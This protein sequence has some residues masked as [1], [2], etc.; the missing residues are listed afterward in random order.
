M[1]YIKIGQ[2]WASRGGSSY[3]R[4]LFGGQCGGNCV[5]RPQTGRNV[6]MRSDCPADWRCSY[7]CARMGC[8]PRALKPSC[9]SALH[10][11]TDGVCW[12]PPHGATSHRPLSQACSPTLMKSI[13]TLQAHSAE[14]QPQRLLPPTSSMEP[15]SGI[16]LLLV[17]GFRPPKFPAPT[18]ENHIQA[19]RRVMSIRRCH[20]QASVASWSLRGESGADRGSLTR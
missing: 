8:A 13:R 11:R 20:K 12:L 5:M 19:I 9:W 6:C 2:C 3:K 1:C 14:R 4:D 10:L 7:I 16:C 18:Q 15:G 17:P